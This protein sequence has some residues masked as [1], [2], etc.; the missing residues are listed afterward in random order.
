V[1]P[2]VNVNVLESLVTNAQRWRV[3]DDS[4]LLHCVHA[5]LDYLRHLGERQL[6]LSRSQHQYYSQTAFTFFWRRFARAFAGLG[7]AAQAQLD[8][9]HAVRYLDALLQEWWG[10]TVRPSGGG[11]CCNT[12]DLLLLCHA[13]PE[14][15]ADLWPSI[16]VALAREPVCWEYEVFCVLYPVKNAYTSRAFVASLLLNLP[17]SPDGV[18]SIASSAGVHEGPC[19]GPVRMV[20]SK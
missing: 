1:D 8:P 4:F 7:A 15:A 20:Q 13:Y 16:T 10:R 6:L 19:H 17:R 9:D 12:L 3:L 2:T 14:R 11:L 18:H 5:M